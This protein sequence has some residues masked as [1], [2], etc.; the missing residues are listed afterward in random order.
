[1][2]FVQ[3]NS[4]R[5]IIKLD[6]IWNFVKDDESSGVQKGYLNGLPSCRR[7]AVPASW[8]E[9]YNDLFHYRKQAWYEKSFAIPNE[10]KGK[11]AILRFSS[12]LYRAKVF[13]NG[14]YVGEISRPYL[15]FEFDV[16][17]FLLFGVENRL[18]VCVDGAY[19]KDE[20]IFEADF[21]GYCG[22]NRPV[23]LSFVDLVHIEDIRLQTRLSD[24]GGVAAIRI[25]TTGGQKVLVNIADME[26]ELSI[27]D[28]VAE[29]DIW[30]QGIIPWS[31][32]NP[33]LY[34]VVVELYENGQIKDS[35]KLRTGFRE[36][37]IE[38]RNIILNGSPVKLKGFCRHEDFPI[39]GRGMMDALN[40]RDFDL[41]KWCGAN[42]FRTSHYPYAEE[43]LDLADEMGFLVID[44][45]PFVALGLEKF[46]DPNI[47]HK[48]KQYLNTLIDRDKNHPCV[49][50]WSIGNEC[51]TNY[52]EAEEFFLELIHIARS[53]D[54]R[55]ITY[56]A[57]TRPEE[58]VVYRHVDIIGTNRYFGWYSM[59]ESWGID[60][61]QGD[62]TTAVKELDNSLDN[63]ASLYSSP[64]LLSEF[65]A[66]TIAG[67]HSAFLLQF[68]EEFQARF[69][70]E[71][72]R[73][74]SFKEYVC[75]THV[76]NFADFYT[77]QNVTRVTGNRKGVFTRDRQPK[78]AAF[79]LR[80]LW[81][82]LDGD[83]LYGLNEV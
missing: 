63:F 25:E 14:L 34:D 26:T 82:G 68:T 59:K 73:L 67:L 10:T 15:P 80:K 70:T 5:M 47:L 52:K 8:N 58:D 51:K 61:E 46:T 78:M 77:H 79:A 64:I 13:L 37:A 19:P 4:E 35:Y 45:T 12:V 33:S 11:L 38:G 44:E 60:C 56:V 24:D 49:F 7:I 22:I 50:T 40:V 55:P 30:I 54:D 57:W 9:Q 28:S 27:N 74:A 42:S 72:I 48:A 39:I 71:Y 43:I 29:G 75:G 18:S 69:L 66:D 20:P 36:I 1:M 21:Y 41:M 2:L 31:I 65:G 62:I 32:E 16:T 6:G 76:W 81:T 3:G 53:K 83:G 23:Y 17:Y